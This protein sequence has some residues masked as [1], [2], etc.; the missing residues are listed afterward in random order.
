MTNLR[1]LTI[2]MLCSILSACATYSDPTIAGRAETA[3]LRFSTAPMVAV[4]IVG[5]K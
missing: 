3:Y 5:R 1:P 4:D 2:L